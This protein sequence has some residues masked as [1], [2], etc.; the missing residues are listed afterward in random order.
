MAQNAEHPE[1]KSALESNGLQAATDGFKFSIFREGELYISPKVKMK[2]DQAS[3][4]RLQ[5]FCIGAKIAQASDA[6]LVVS[7]GI[8][9]CS[10]HDHY[11]FTIGREESLKRKI[12]LNKVVG[13]ET[14]EI[15]DSLL[16]NTQ[17]L[18]AFEKVEKY[19]D[20]I[21]RK[22]YEEGSVKEFINKYTIK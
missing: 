13:K 22:I 15:S 3:K 16:L 7:Y 6:S 4:K 21:A 20:L 2:K 19:F 5:K 14:K 11:N 12:V 18:F 17:N 1:A 10:H 8:S 9:L